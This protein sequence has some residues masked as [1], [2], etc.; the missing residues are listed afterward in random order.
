MDGQRSL[1]PRGKPVPEQ[2]SGRICDPV[3][4]QVYAGAALLTR[5][6]TVWGT[7]AVAIC[8]RRLHPMERI[9]AGAVN[10]EL[11]SLGRTHIGKVVEDCLL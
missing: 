5:L 8:S 10:E 3:E 6:A 4:R 1:R 11:Q 9:Q 7:Y 2:A